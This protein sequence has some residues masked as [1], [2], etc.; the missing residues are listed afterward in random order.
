MLKHVVG[1]PI[2]E[3]LNAQAE[4]VIELLRSDASRSEKIEAADELIFQFVET[5]IDYHFHE[6][7]RRFGLNTFLVKMIDVA[8]MTTLRALKTATRRVLKGLNDEQ[9]TGVADELEERLYP[10]EVVEE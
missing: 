3:E 7:A 2:T 6:P 10:V 8:A 9:L 5:G 4:A 1:T